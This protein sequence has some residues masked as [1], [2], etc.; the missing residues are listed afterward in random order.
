MST[1][2]YTRGTLHIQE[3]AGQVQTCDYDVPDIHGT[4]AIAVHQPMNVTSGATTLFNGTVDETVLKSLESPYRASGLVPEGARVWSVKAVGRTYYAYHILTGSFSAQR[5]VP[6][7]LVVQTL[8]N[9]A[10]LASSVDAP[11]LLPDAFLSDNEPLSSAL[12]RLADLASSLSGTI[13]LWRIDWT[14]VLQFWPIGTIAG[15]TVGVGGVNPKAGSISIRVTRQQFSNLIVLKLGH[16]LKDPVQTDT[17][18]PGDIFLGTLKLSYPC[19]GAPTVSV[20]GQPTQTVGLKDLDTGKDW[21]WSLGSSVITLGS[22]STA[23]TITVTYQGTDARS[24]TVQD[25]PSIGAVGVFASAIEAGDL[26]NSLSP[27]SLAIAELARRD[28]LTVVVKAIV[29]STSFEVGQL[30]SVNLAFG[31]KG[32]ALGNYYLNSVRTF[33]DEAL[34]FWQELELM[35]GPQLRGASSHMM[36]MTR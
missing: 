32:V 14:G 6:L 25:V 17:F 23:G 26:L 28:G 1:H 12:T 13:Y 30:C 7:A 3:T 29:R 20:A 22:G 33:D 11:M 31:N 18:N 24:L 4:T 8:A 19:A 15:P 16:Y 34:V 27:Q 9:N 5:R 2:N 10:G 35:Q 21:Y 36:R